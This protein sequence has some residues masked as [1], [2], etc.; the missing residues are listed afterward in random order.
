MR[1][2][3]EYRIPDTDDKGYSS[4]KSHL[5]INSVGYYEFD[6]EYGATYRPKGRKDYY[7]SYN[8]SGSMK[9]RSKYQNHII[10]GGTVFLYRPF[11]EQHYGQAD[12][13][14]ISNYWVHFTGYGCPEIIKLA[15]MEEG[16][17][18]SVG[19][20]ET[21]PQLFEIMIDEIAKKQ[22]N[23]ELVS[24]SILQQVIYLLSRKLCINNTVKID[25]KY[26]RINQTM[27][28]IRKHYPEKITLKQL[29]GMAG[30]SC[31]RYSY[32]F[33]EYSGISPQ[34]YLINV[35]LEKA[36][37]LMSHTRLNIRQISSLIGFGDQ[38]YFSRLFKKYKSTSPSEF[39]ESVRGI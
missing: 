28:Y 27:V 13:N 17:I 21:I 11:E 12:N 5:L 14:P 1:Y 33:K 32:L 26:S 9:V 7:L 38:L 34:Q 31:S 37:E 19:I 29:A 20:S 39:I 4:N 6:E 2:T 36:Q 10:H 3:A 18:F 23:Y 22:Y 24:A 16:N 8:H 30:L 35:R 25:E 15:N